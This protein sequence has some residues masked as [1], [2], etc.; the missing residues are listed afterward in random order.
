MVVFLDGLQGVNLFPW[1]KQITVYNYRALSSHNV[2]I[3]NQ[4]SSLSRRKNLH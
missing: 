4:S 3:A 1:G 2:P